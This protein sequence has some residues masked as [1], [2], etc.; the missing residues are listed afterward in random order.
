MNMKIKKLFVAGLAALAVAGLPV[1]AQLGAPMTVINSDGGTAWTNRLYGASAPASNTAVNLTKIALPKGSTGVSLQFTAHLTGAGTDPV[2]IVLARNV[3]G[4]T[5]VEPFLVWPFVPTG[6]AYKTQCTNLYD[7]S[8]GSPG[9]FPNIYVM[10]I[11]NSAAN[12][13]IMTNYT[14]KAFVH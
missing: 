5:N 2:N 1:F 4:S 13:V 12:T 9:G 7:G 10:Y 6:T 14:L 3:D 8:L 11:T